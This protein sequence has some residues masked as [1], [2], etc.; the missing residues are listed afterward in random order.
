MSLR[1]TLGCAV[2]VTA[3]VAGCAGQHVGQPLAWYRAREAD[4]R[5]RGG[6]L[7]ARWRAMVPYVW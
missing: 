2:L 3:L 4:G 1:R 5:L 7:P 6:P